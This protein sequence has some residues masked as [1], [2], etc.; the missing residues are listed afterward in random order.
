[1]APTQPFPRVTR[2]FRLDT[3][4][5]RVAN[6]CI[7]LLLLVLLF[8][9][10]AQAQGGVPLVTVATDQSSL[11]LSNQF[12]PP[13]STAIG[14]AGDFAF[15]GDGSGALFFRA[16][17]AAAAS[18]VLQTGDAVPGIS[19]SQI[20]AILP[21]IRLNSKKV[22]LFGISYSLPDGLSHTALLTYDGA[23]FNT[24][25]SSDSIAPG[26]GGLAYGTSL[27]PIGVNDNGDVAFRTSPAG[28]P[29][30]T[31]Y[32]VPSGASVIRVVGP[33]D[34]SPPIPPIWPAVCPN[35]SICFLG[36][37]PAFFAINPQS[38][39]NALG[40]VLFSAGSG[41]L[42]LASATGVNA[43]GATASGNCG[44]GIGFNG[45]LNNSGSVA[46][47]SSFPIPNGT[48][49]A[50]GICVVPPGSAPVV[51]ILSGAAVPSPVGGTLASPSLLGLDDSGNVILT[52][53]TQAT[54]PSFALLRYHLDG[55]IDVV[56]Y[57]GETA[58]GATGSTFE[59]YFEGV[60]V[61]A[62]GLVSFETIL[63]SGP[64]AIYQ[65]S[66]AGAPVLLVMDGQ[67]APLSGGAT[68]KLFTPE[69]TSTLA[70]GATYFSATTPSGLPY[71]AA[72]L[73]APSSIH[74]LMTTDDSLLPGSKV[75]LITR[76]PQAAGHFVGFGAQEAGGFLALFVTDLSSGTTQRVVTRGDA[77]P[78]T[79]GV[80]SAIG[81][82]SYMNTNGQMVFAA[83]IAGGAV[84]QAIFLWSPSTGL[85]K[86]VAVGDVSPI[87]GATFSQ[88]LTPSL[89]TSTISS[90]ATLSP[91]NDS[92]QVVF[93]ATYS[94]TKSG[95]GVFL[96]QA[97]GTIAKIYA[98]G[99]PIVSNDPF[100]DTAF[101]EPGVFLNQAGQVAFQ[102]LFEFVDPAKLPLRTNVSFGLYVGSAT[103]SPALAFTAG[104]TVP[105]L[106]DG[107][108]LNA[109]NF[110]PNFSDSGQ[111][112]FT[113]LDFPTGVTTTHSV[114]E[115]GL[116][117]ASTF[118]GA[119]VVALSGQQAP[120][121]GIGT[122]SL[123]TIIKLATNVTGT[124]GIDFALGNGS[125]DFA[126]RAGITGGTTDSG[127]FRLLLS[128]PNAGT[129]QPVVFQGQAVPQAGSSTGGGGLGTFNTIPPPGTQDANFAIGPDGSLAFVNGFT[130]GSSPSEG[131]FVAQRNGTILRAL[132][133]GDSVPGVGTVNGISMSQGLAAGDPGKFA[134]WA[135]IQGG[136]TQQAIF[137][138]AIPQGAATVTTVSP[139]PNPGMFGQV[140]TITATVSTTP[141]G[142]PTG[143]VS[144]L[145][146][147]ILLGTSTLGAGQATLSISSLA[148]GS[149]SIT[150]QY[151][152]DSN[153]A[154]S[155]SA[156]KPLVITPRTT[157]TTLASSLNPAV[158]GQSVTFTVAVTMSAGGAPTGTVT[159][160]DGGTAIGTG[161]LD[162]SAAAT[163]ST[164]SL[165]V[166]SHSITA[167][168]GGDMNSATSAS[169][170]LMETV[171]IA[172]IVPP[173]APPTVTAGQSLNIPLTLFGAPG[174]NLVFTLSCSGL[175][176]A[177]SCMFGSNPVS[178]GPPP[179]GTGLQLTFSTTKRSG[180]VPGG[181]RRGPISLWGLGLAA[182]LAALFA[183]AALPWMRAPRWRLVSRASLA[184]FVLALA[185]GGC[186]ASSYSSN[187]P[188]TPGTPAG[189][190]AFTVT[191][192]SGATTISTV[193]NVTV[194]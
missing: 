161:T 5:R 79:G 88:L 34:P 16:A 110:V 28:L 82:Y 181:T 42:F 51:Q 80:I 69:G 162:G 90:A 176:A 179:S 187:T 103:A 131:I 13:A 29:D 12:G 182:L 145:D 170:A 156:A 60:S 25:A 23:G 141:T 98:N 45:I 89:S 70:S 188:V 14:P 49:T 78:R 189:P 50:P 59:S 165:S 44:D 39:I 119:Q 160:F 73:G 178:A 67:T 27:A 68:F 194:K 190:A 32:I 185:M 9:S 106:P 147:G 35:P 174:S 41:G 108:F 183:A 146:N 2:T 91:L 61:A 121:A 17:G 164:T 193:V 53:G 167:S 31:I 38:G 136:S 163:L 134:F 120:G 56:A 113:G 97:D 100:P 153:F 107:G 81:R 151:S 101:L 30:Y 102:V 92:G 36:G 93:T 112:L 87:P 37:Q 55:S 169:A 66:G 84:N 19:N 154:L 184:A 168:Y 142:T 177:T 85:A 18:R 138:T 11:N 144:F 22:L 130:N 4:L 7:I 137:A 158:G 58:P 172:A 74:P 148:V 139:S 111:L 15:V 105:D 155:N 159:F 126:F 157:T 26:S 114:P 171:S 173:S 48:G 128:G 116:F 6:S 192:T 99:D 46:I 118:G 115:Y 83:T 8:C 75:T 95:T 21:T 175:P 152:G 125:G 47:R 72:F 117:S 57:G 133:S 150:A 191:G 20:L 132:A 62:N 63:T 86:V 77:A 64:S 94:G 122:Y 166:A 71:F 52:S 33:G 186:G 1:M 43:V 40:E 54:G 140:V 76:R 149:H 143:S 104:A 123:E 135:G 129:I 127:Y 96:Y 3:L 180:I 65:Q 24:V 109:I 10:A 124:Q